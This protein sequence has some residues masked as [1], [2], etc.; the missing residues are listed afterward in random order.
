M[1]TKAMEME[2]DELAEILAGL[3][4]N[5]QS[6]FTTWQHRMN[7]TITEL[8][9]GNGALAIRFNGLV[10]DPPDTRYRIDSVARSK[11]IAAEIIETLRW[12]LSRKVPEPNPLDDSAIDPDLWVHVQ[13]LVESGDWNKVALNTAVFVGDKLRAW[14][15]LPPA[16]TGSVDV[17]KAS[18]ATDKLRLGDRPSEQQG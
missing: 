5:R 17:F 12:E 16:V 3:T 15:Q 10:W 7:A 8:V 9:G 14:A 13:G 1:S 6:G 4:N 11:E 2:L 18:L